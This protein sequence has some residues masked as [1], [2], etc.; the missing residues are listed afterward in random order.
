MLVQTQKQTVSSGKFVQIR[1]RVPFGG[2][3]RMSLLLLGYLTVPQFIFV[4]FNQSSLAAGLIGVSAVLALYYVPYG[5]FYVTKWQVVA[6]IVILISIAVSN[7]RLKLTL[8]DRQILSFF[9]WAFVLVSTNNFFGAL[10]G[11]GNRVLKNAFKYSFYF[12]LSLGVLGKLYSLKIGSYGNAAKPIFPFSEESHFSL[13][14]GPVALVYMMQL[15]KAR[16]YLVPLTMLGLALWYPNVTMFLSSLFVLGVILNIRVIVVVALIFAASFLTPAHVLNEINLSYFRDRI[17]T[18]VEGAN[19]S[20][21]VYRQGWDQA[22]IGN[23]ESYGLGLGFQAFGTEADGI[24]VKLIDET[25]N[26]ELNRKDG[27]NL[28]SKIFAEFGILGAAGLLGGAAAGIGAFLCLRRIRRVSAEPAELVYLGVTYIFVLELF[29]R[30]LGYFNPMF[31][32]YLFCLSRTS[33]LRSIWRVFIHQLP[34]SRFQASEST[35]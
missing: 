16:Q 33:I 22:R 29:F 27:S 15:S 14:F 26:I 1:V 28:G 8:L 20:N 34:R 32:L 31:F 25:Y 4:Y 18:P 10:V 13:T 11:S 2:G 23:I 12:L 7:L 19:L 17:Q 3:L 5:K 21:V 35:R 9:A 30:G 6:L 24:Y